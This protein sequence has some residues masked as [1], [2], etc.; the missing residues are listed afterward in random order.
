MRCP[1]GKKNRSSARTE[2]SS[3]IESDMS[4]VLKQAFHANNHALKVASRSVENDDD[5]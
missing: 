1:D 4:H 3:R 5:C 2:E